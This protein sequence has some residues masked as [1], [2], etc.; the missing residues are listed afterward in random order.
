MLGGLLM[1]FISLKLGS[2]ILKTIKEAYS[3]KGKIEETEEI[4]SAPT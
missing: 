3:D 1:A 4:T 2:P